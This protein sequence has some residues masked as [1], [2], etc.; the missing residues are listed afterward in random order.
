M[1]TFGAPFSPGPYFV[2]VMLSSGAPFFF[3]GGVIAAK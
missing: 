1:T 2:A 3:S